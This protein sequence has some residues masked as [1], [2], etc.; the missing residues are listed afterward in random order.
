MVNTTAL[1]SPWSED[2]EEL[3]TQ[4]TYYKLYLD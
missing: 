1:Y 3:E 4:T 2:V